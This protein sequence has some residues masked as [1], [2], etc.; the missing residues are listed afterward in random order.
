MCVVVSLSQRQEYFGVVQVPVG[1]ACLYTARLVTTLGGARVQ[2][3]GGEC[4]QGFCRSVVTGDLKPR[5]SW[6]GHV[7][8]GTW[9]R[10]ALLAG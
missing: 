1:A 2:E 5:P 9:V 4:Y 6:R 3:Q 7:C 10:D 8:R